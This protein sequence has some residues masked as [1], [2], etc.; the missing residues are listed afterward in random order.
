MIGRSHA[1]PRKLP[2]AA[3]ADGC[4]I[5]VPAGVAR[6]DRRAGCAPQRGSR[7]AWRD[8]LLAVASTT[9]GR[10]VGAVE[11]G[12]V[13]CSA[14]RPARRASRRRRPRDGAHLGAAARVRPRPTD[15]GLWDTLM[16][17]QVGAGEIDRD[18][19]SC[20]RDAGGGRCSTFAAICASSRGGDRLTTCSRPGRE[21]L[22]GRAL[23]CL[24]RAP[25]RT[26]SCRVNRDGGGRALRLPRESGPCSEAPARRR[27]HAEATL[28]LGADA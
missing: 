22:H 27:V 18:R 26:A 7:G 6:G 1:S 2:F 28:I 13:A 15:P 14:W 20:T 3:I 5:A 12:V 19:R 4:G 21:R 8:E 10:N 24:S 17:G 16:G 23:G 9:E 25:A 11:R